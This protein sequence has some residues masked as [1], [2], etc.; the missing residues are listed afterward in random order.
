[1]GSHLTISSRAILK[2]SGFR[3]PQFWKVSFLMAKKPDIGSVIAEE[4]R[5]FASIVAPRLIIRRES[6]QCST[7]RP[8]MY[9]DPRTKSPFPLTRGS[10]RFGIRSGGCDKSASMT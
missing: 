8:S 9:L 2:P 1:M 4:M 10:M 7:Q 6:V 3:D 5:G